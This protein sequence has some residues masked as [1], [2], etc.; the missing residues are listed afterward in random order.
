[1][2]W[3]QGNPL[4]IAL[5]AVGGL[6]AL[7]ALGMAIAWN[8]PI[9][10]DA[11]DMVTDNVVDDLTPLAAEDAGS[12]NDYRIVD[13][14]PVFNES[15]QPEIIEVEDVTEQTT[16]NAIVVKG[17]PEVKLTGVIITPAMKI[18]SLTP[19]DTSQESVMAHE[20]QSLTGEYVGW[21]VNAVNPRDVVLRSNDGRQLE[22]E[23][24]V[25][26]VAI[27]EP[28]K[29]KPVAKAAKA[30]QSKQT[31]ADKA[32][33]GAGDDEEPLSRAEQIRQRIAE[34]REELR[35]EQE[36]QG[37]QTDEGKSQAS[38]SRP[39]NSSNAYQ[40]AI[41]ARITK[42]SEDKESDDEKDG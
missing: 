36:A 29:P 40:N 30:G 7:L 22:L 4:G 38:R 13:E 41:Q 16:D 8:L 3:L 11:D 21:Q 2:K 32:K 28:P 34:R 27:K 20:G 31:E 12:L 1:M 19:V 6:L 17:A 39:A 35:R 9:A 18:A 5:V 25:H 33:S 26:D 15:R 10:V 24:Q 42:G 37:Q 23:L 14:R